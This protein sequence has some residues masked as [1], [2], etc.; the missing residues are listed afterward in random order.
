[1]SIPVQERNIVPFLENLQ[2]HL[3]EIG[4]DLWANQLSQILKPL[5]E[6]LDRRQKLENFAETIA[7]AC[8]S[9]DAVERF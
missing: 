2:T 3:R 8:F 7:D 5:S 1:M 4:D 9:I 6:A